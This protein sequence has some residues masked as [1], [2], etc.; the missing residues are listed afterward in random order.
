MWLP[1]F[2]V[3]QVIKQNC[4]MG[5][6]TACNCPPRECKIALQ[7]GCGGRSAG[8]SRSEIND[9]LE[10][11]LCRCGDRQCRHD[12]WR[13]GDAGHQS[14]PNRS[15][16]TR[17]AIRPAAGPLGLPLWVLAPPGSL[18]GAAHLVAADMVAAY[19]VAPW[20]SMVGAVGLAPSLLL[21]ASLLA[22]PVAVATATR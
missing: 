5:L 18:V 13:V 16:S 7:V 2:Q 19:L 17:I 12:R 9:A 21:A 8:N 4:R 20:S 10:V 6:A 3:K 22:S 11:G 14:H 1:Q 15:N